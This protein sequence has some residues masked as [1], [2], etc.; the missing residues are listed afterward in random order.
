MRKLSHRNKREILWPFIGDKHDPNANEDLSVFDSQ[1]S[2]QTEPDQSPI[3]AG[4][5]LQAKADSTD[6][7]EQF[8][9]SH[10]AI[11]KSDLVEQALKLGLKVEDL[12]DDGGGDSLSWCLMNLRPR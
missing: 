9:S 7:P 3:N 2:D 4:G 11:L 12:R 6:N 10:L 5:F 1:S 8:E